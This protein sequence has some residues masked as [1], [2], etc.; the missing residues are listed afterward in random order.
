MDLIARV[1]KALPAEAFGTAKFESV[2]DQA[3][4][5]GKGRELLLRFTADHKGAAGVSMFAIGPF[6]P[7]TCIVGQMKGAVGRDIY[8]DT[9]K[10]AFDIP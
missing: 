7:K 1:D 9:D 4:L 3:R 5:S 2:E 6:D 10:D 8:N